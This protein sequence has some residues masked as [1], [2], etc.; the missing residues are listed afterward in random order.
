VEVYGGLLF[1]VVFREMKEMEEMKMEDKGEGGTRQPQGG[2]RG[3]VN[4]V[5][6]GF[7]FVLTENRITRR[8]KIPT[9]L[10]LLNTPL[11]KD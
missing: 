1:V 6:L 8:T 3:R 11:L 10:K 9:T 4:S 7:W 5:L 2:K